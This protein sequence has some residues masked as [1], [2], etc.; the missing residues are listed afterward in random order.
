MHYL[1]ILLAVSLAVSAVGWKYFIYFFSLG[2][3][4]ALAT[5]PRRR[6]SIIGA[7]LIVGLEEGLLWYAYELHFPN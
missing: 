6:Q 3:G 2:H 7:L 1:L 5:L 4:G